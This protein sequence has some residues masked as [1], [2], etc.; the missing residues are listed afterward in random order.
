MILN[1]L[2]KKYKFKRVNEYN[3]EAFTS[4][5]ALKGECRHFRNEIVVYENINTKEFER[6]IIRHEIVHAFL[7]E[8]GLENYK[9]NED[10]VNLIAHQFPKMLEVFKKVDAI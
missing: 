5:P 8:C 3:D 4:N 1:I 9:N 7:H 10:L 6:F 2:G